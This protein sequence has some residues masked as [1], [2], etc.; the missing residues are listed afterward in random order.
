MGIQQEGLFYS[1]P[2]L[3]SIKCSGNGSETQYCSSHRAAK[4]III[5]Q[6]DNVFPYTTYMLRSTVFGNS[7]YESPDVQSNG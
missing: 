6:G 4:Q 1:A 3:N 7:C 5:S 2:T